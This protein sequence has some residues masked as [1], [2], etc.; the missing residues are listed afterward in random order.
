[1]IIMCPNMEKIAKNR[2]YSIKNSKKS[3]FKRFNLFWVSGHPQ[4]MQL[5]NGY[6][7]KQM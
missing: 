3:F 4:G 2:I 5:I 7:S 6:W 1:M